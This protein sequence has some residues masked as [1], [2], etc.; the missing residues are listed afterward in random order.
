MNKSGGV[1]TNIGIHFFDMLMWIFG[2][3]KLQEVHLSDEKKMAGF[4]E[5]KNAH[6]RWFLSV[7]PNDLPEQIKSERKTTYRSIM[8]EGKEIEFS[9]G[10]TDLHTLVYQDIIKGGG[11]WHRGCSPIH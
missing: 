8:I 11:I 5:L 3:V 10:F 7:D 2:S 4:L 9:D 6:I 1:V